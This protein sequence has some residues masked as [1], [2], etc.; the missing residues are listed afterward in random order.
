MEEDREMNIEMI[1]NGNF[2]GCNDNDKNM[3]KKEMLKK[4]KCYRFAVKRL[5][6]FAKAFKFFEDRRIFDCR[7][8]QNV[9]GNASF[10]YRAR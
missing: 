8:A 3:T 6:S 4:I 7:L 5:V 10:R 2:C 9:R 1:M